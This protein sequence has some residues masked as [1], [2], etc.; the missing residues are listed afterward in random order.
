VLATSPDPGLRS[1]CPE[2]LS[3][4]NFGAEQNT[5]RNRN[6]LLFNEVENQSKDE[7]DQNAGHDG[8]VKLKTASLDQDVSRQSAQPEPG[9]EVRIADDQAND[10]ERNSDDDKNTSHR[11]HSRTRFSLGRKTSGRPF[12]VSPGE[13]SER[14][15]EA[16]TP[17]GRIRT[18]SVASLEPVKEVPGL[19]CSRLGSVGT[20][21]RVALD[22]DA[23]LL[24]Q[25]SWSGFGWIGRAHEPAPLSDRPFPR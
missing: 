3:R 23:K 24:A 14:T 4:L 22:R 15:P 18:N 21:S 17:L 6:Y 25:C 20:M 1:A 8:E 11:N 7:A 2:L 5:F 10:N 13:V 12:R 16:R 19:K 9:K